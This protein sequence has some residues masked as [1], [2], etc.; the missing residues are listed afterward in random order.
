MHK[1]FQA[2]FKNSNRPP[3]VDVLAQ[4]IKVLHYTFNFRKKLRTN[5]ETVQNLANRMS[6]YGINVGTPAI[7]HMLL[8]NI[9]TATK[10]NTDESFNQQCREY[11]PSTRTTTN[12]TTRP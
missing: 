12:P 2:A 1:V 8:A 5:M 6:A 7:A 9:E 11:A 4:L 3:M 10:Q